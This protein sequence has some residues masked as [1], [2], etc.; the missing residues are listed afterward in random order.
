M[1]FHPLSEK[2]LGNS[3]E[4]GSDDEALVGDIMM[5]RHATA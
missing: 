3:K 5:V 2:T 4:S 1:N